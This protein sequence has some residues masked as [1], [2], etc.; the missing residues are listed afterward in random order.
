M[1]DLLIIPITGILAGYAGGSLPFSYI[2]D[3]IKATW[4]PE[5]LF[6]MVL[7]YHAVLI[8]KGLGWL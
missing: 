8:Y 5:L 7:A 4:L 6:A 1:I 3:K 2:F